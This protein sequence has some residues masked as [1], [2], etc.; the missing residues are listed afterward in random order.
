MSTYV[1]DIVLGSLEGN[2]L[3]R[4]LVFSLEMKEMP[5]FWAITCSLQEVSSPHYDAY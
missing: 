5:N 3:S 4:V 2:H 1:P